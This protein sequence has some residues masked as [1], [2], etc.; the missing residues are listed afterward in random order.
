M[1]AN[2]DNQLPHLLQADQ[3]SYHPERNSS[4]NVETATASGY[5]FQSVWNLFFIN[6]F[7]CIMIPK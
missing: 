7:T 3:I 5:P 6:L 2:K 1:D 4:S